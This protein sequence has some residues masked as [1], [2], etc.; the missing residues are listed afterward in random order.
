[1]IPLYVTAYIGQPIFFP[2]W[3][4]V[5]FKPCLP[6]Q[7]EQL[8]LNLIND[9]HYEIDFCFQGIEK[10]DFKT[11]KRSF[12]SVSMSQEDEFPSRI[13]AFSMLPIVFTF[14]GVVRG[15]LMNRLSI[16]LVSPFNLDFN[17]TISG[18]L[19]TLVGICIEPYPHKPGELPDKNGIEFLRMWM[20]HP[21]RLIDEYPEDEAEREKRFDLTTAIP[22][23]RGTANS[24]NLCEVTFF[25]DTLIFRHPR[26]DKAIDDVHMRRSQILPIMVQHRGVKELPTEFF[27]STFYN[28]D[29]RIRDMRKGDTVNFD[30]MFTPPHDAMDNVT[31]Y[32]FGIAIVQEDHTFHAI[33]LI[34]KPFTDFLV[35]PIIGADGSV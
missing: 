26:W 12:F 14:T 8:S 19:L 16:R 18:G 29:P 6:G 28:I 7:S 17:A 11:T 15:P 2:V 23:N 21:K 32:G 4:F 27:G 24:N 25:K 33:Q 13:R 30:V 31:T 20:S 9:S 35:Y 22:Q 3:D 34:T 10:V 5:F 1:N